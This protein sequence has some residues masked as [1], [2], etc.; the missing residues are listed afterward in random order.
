MRELF[1]LLD[2]DVY[3]LY[4]SVSFA[5]QKHLRKGPDVIGSS[6][7]KTVIGSSSGTSQEEEDPQEEVSSALPGHRWIPP[8]VYESGFEDPSEESIIEEFGN[9]F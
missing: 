5:D 2:E 9:G 8:Y 3:E 7:I 4:V 6:S 1:N